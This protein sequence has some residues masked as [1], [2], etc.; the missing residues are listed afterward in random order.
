MFEPTL[1]FH[2]FLPQSSKVGSLSS[3]TPQI[4]FCPKLGF[5]IYNGGY[6]GQPLS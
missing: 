5:S 3:L 1:N 6:I 2:P 4:Q